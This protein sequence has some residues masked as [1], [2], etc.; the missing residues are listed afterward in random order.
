MQNFTLNLLKKNYLKN[1]I[2]KKLARPW[3]LLV[4][5]STVKS[6]IFSFCWFPD[7]SGQ[8][9]ETKISWFKAGKLTVT[10]EKEFSLLSLKERFLEQI[11]KNPY[12]ANYWWTCFSNYVYGT[13]LIILKIYAFLLLYFTTGLLLILPSQPASFA[14][15]VTSTAAFYHCWS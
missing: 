3:K 10:W 1:Q 11:E 4:W 2:F 12:I 8:L 14:W 9:R 15:T 7:T 13:I 5:P 6:L